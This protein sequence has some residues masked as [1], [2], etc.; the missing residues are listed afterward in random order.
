MQ[1]GDGASHLHVRLVRPQSNVQRGRGLELTGGYR[2]VP[3]VRNEHEAGLW[4]ELAA[5]LRAKG[6][7]PPSRSVARRV[8]T[9]AL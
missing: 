9:R 5:Q 8:L 1:W 6:T 3:P 7:E 4:A 2:S